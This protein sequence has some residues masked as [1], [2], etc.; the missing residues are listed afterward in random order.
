MD[1]LTLKLRYS[2]KQNVLKFINNIVE[3]IQ[4]YRKHSAICKDM[5]LTN[6]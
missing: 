1:V 3:Y 6:Y 2:Y 4:I 5:K